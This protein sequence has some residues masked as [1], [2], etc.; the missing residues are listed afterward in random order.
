VQVIPHS[1]KFQPG[2]RVLTYRQAPRALAYA[3]R[4]RALAPPILVAVTQKAK[5]VL[6]LALALSDHERRLIAHALLDAM[7][8]EN[9]SSIEAA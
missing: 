7:S 2:V 1:L 8:P 6:D 9:A 3:D 5:Q 4:P